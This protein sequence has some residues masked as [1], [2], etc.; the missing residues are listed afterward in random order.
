MMSPPMKRPSGR[1]V[2][3]DR[4]PNAP[5]S[6][7]AHRVS[8][9]TTVPELERSASRTSINFSYPIISPR[10]SPTFT[11]S[12][13]SQSNAG[14]HVS[15]D[16]LSAAETEDIQFTVSQ[17]AE[18]P[19]KRKKKRTLAPGSAEGSHLAA[20]T[21][22]GH[23]VGTAVAAAHGASSPVDD[24]PK[25]VAQNHYPDRPVTQPGYQQAREKTPSPRSFPEDQTTVP[26]TQVT[27]ASPT[28][29]TGDDYQEQRPKPKR[30]PSTVHEDHEAEEQAE[31]GRDLAQSHTLQVRVSTPE[32]A[33]VVLTDNEARDETLIIPGL[34]PSEA[35]TEASTR[36]P[37]LP[38][39]DRRLSINS[40][41]EEV[42]PGRPHSISPSRSARFSTQLTV[43]NEGEPLHQPPPRSMSPA[44]SAMKHSPQQSLSPERRT[45]LVIRPGQ[46]LSE[47]SDGT[48]VASDEGSRSGPR[49][50]VTKVSFDDE[51]EIVGVAASPPTSPEDIVPESPL[52]KAKPKTN[53]FGLGKKKTSL[54]DKFNDDEFGDYLKPRPALPSFG[55]IRGHKDVEQSEPVKES[56]NN[57]ESITSSPS[58]DNAA[59]TVVHGL[60]NDPA[61]S[62]IVANSKQRI[63]QQPSEPEEPNEPIPSEVP[64]DKRIE[65]TLNTED[66]SSLTR[67]SPVTEIN[68]SQE[69][70][71][72]PNDH[73]AHEETDTILPYPPQDKPT[74]IG[75]QNK[76]VPVIAV[77]PATPRVEEGRPSIELSRI[78]GGF[79][80]STGPPNPPAAE[81]P[82]KAP[83][84][85]PPVTAADENK[86]DSD[87]GDSIYSDAAEDI[88]EVEGDGFGSINAIVDTPVKKRTAE[89]KTVEPPRGAALLPLVETPA[90]QSDAAEVP[91]VPLTLQNS[92][93]EPRPF[94][95]P[96]PPWP[97]HH[98]VQEPRAT[99]PPVANMKRPM[100]PMSVDPHQGSQL[101]S[102]LYA[103]GNQASKRHSMSASPVP[104]ARA[105]IQGSGKPITSPNSSLQNGASADASGK[106]TDKTVSRSSQ[107][108]PGGLHR[109]SSNGSDS[110]SSFKR[111]R[112]SSKD[113]GNVALRKTM[114][115][116]GAGRRQ[117][118]DKITSL[119][120][121]RPL[122]SGPTSGIM[123]TTLRGPSAT[124]S[125]QDKSSIFS[126]R[127][128]HSKG[129]SSGQFTSRF[130][131][132]SDDD[133]AGHSHKFRSRFEDSS[134][135][136]PAVT[137]LRPVRGIPRRRG[138]NDGDST[139]LEDS[140]DDEAPPT[141]YREPVSEQTPS[142]P[143]SVAASLVR[144][145]TPAELQEFLSQPR[146]KGIFN[147]L[148]SKRKSTLLER[149]QAELNRTREEQ[150]LNAHGGNFVTTITS[151]NASPSSP[152]LQ[153]RFPGNV[154][155]HDSWP[156]R[157]PEPPREREDEEASVAGP[158]ER[159]LTSDG[160]SDNPWATRFKP[161][162]RRGTG[163]TISTA[164]DVVVGRNGK[165]K[166]F[167]LLRRAFG[168]KD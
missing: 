123:R 156:L 92:A 109:T 34:S 167:P 52:D 161:F 111:S 20:G 89:L 114:R 30:L 53:W 102:A 162:N 65:H 82:Q 62:G 76:T 108:F 129:K 107:S 33:T 51:A 152:K 23:P 134:D 151:D 26:G 146:K 100:R 71:S 94:E 165:K 88:S 128:K 35:V 28:P 115:G 137:T 166:R 119:N 99:S 84:T 113:D 112:R 158:S 163:S 8:N 47:I 3:L 106:G 25:Q 150:F 125:Q 154:N 142:D 147:R 121:A 126:G 90:L 56:V 85:Q 131:D 97:I 141:A 59:T 7:S 78:P 66:H 12:E 87:S 4:A 40:T 27:G 37:S 73:R 36:Q 143:A 6:R 54:A 138:A 95:S 104:G 135:D 136:E 57:H 160:A 50:K 149:S 60:S 139:D 140:S 122:S 10:Q 83:T 74:T 61:I 77:Q 43:S 153:K 86:T 80:S 29:Q 98:P 67:Q 41:Q 49:K 16:G 14:D 5:A 46:A 11:R 31:A 132:D 63:V 148:T 44:K 159:P 144:N 118:P 13:S 17:A 101:R 69:I 9:L 72:S 79:P 116:S 24:P 81:S 48:S 64:T 32:Q 157:S 110:S 145:M 124:G 155:G 22:G 38:A 58:N 96:Y 168:L 18:K 15:V 120:G 164:S 93:D 75:G 117:S 105:S 19:V 133:L 42:R 1:G 70:T 91:Y 130:D 21:V 39:D 2:S 103:S 45:P 68:G 55:S 127:S